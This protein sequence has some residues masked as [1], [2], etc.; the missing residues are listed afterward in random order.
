[1]RGACQ[2]SSAAVQP[3][4]GVVPTSSSAAMP[5]RKL[6]SASASARSESPDHQ[7]SS[8]KVAEN[9]RTSAARPANPRIGKRAMYAADNQQDRVG[10]E[11][12]LRRGRCGRERDQEHQQR[13]KFSSGITLVQRT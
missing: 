6:F 11:G 4:S 3:V 12:R 5:E 2:L 9:G 13:G 1:M 7:V 10:G 8:A